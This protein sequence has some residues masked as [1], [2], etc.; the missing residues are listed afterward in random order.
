MAESAFTITQRQ[1]P[2]GLLRVVLT[3]D[4]DMSIG[5]TLSRTLL[6]AAHRPGVERIVVDLE[7]TTFIDS[8]VVAA[9]VAGYEAAASAGRRLTVVN[10]RG[11]VQQVLDVTGLTEVLCA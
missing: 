9:L 7:R 4:L 1:D 6:D 3:G 5:D 2:P 10:G 8:H 11:I